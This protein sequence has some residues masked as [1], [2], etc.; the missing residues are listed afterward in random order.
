MYIFTLT[1]ICQVDPS[2]ITLWTDPFQ[3]KG[4]AFIITIFYRN[5]FI[6]IAVNANSVDPDQT[7]RY[8]ACDLGLHCLQMYLS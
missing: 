8:A 4:L 7:H 5:C 3:S 6:E 2:T 1:R